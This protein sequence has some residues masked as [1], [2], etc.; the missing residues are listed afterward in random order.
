LDKSPPKLVKRINP[1]VLRDVYRGKA[2]NIKSLFIEKRCMWIGDGVR[3]R[4]NPLFFA[5][6]QSSGF[7]CHKVPFNA[8]LAWN[9]GKSKTILPIFAKASLFLSL[10]IT[11][12]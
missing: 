3:I 7:S 11:S 6:F 9:S 4:Q 8:Y 5:R 12:K 1:W 2:L 10:I